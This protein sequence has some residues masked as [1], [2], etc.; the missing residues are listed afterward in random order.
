MAKRKL[1]LK[2][3][4]GAVLLVGLF[5]LL[6]FILV[7]RF[8]Y[9]MVTGHSNGQNLVMKANEKYLVKILSNQSVVK[10]MIAMGR[11]LQKMLKGIKLLQLSIKGKSK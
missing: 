1:K 11:F 4:I 9:I 6:F 8:S 5:G 7:L 10:F 2:N 3:K